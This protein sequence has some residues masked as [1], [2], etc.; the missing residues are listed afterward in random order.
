MKNKNLPKN[1][2]KALFSIK[3]N[4]V[5][6]NRKNDKYVINNKYNFFKY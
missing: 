4:L 6:N 2:N 1:E 5:E 3:K